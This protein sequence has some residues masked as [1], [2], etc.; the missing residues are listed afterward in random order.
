MSADAA[1]QP[2]TMRIDLLQCPEHGAGL[3]QAPGSLRCEMGHEIAV[4]RG[5][6]I[7]TRNARREETPSNMAALA[8]ESA[9]GA[10][11]AFVDDWIVNTHG[12]LYWHLRGHLPR[13]PIPEWPGR[14]A[15]KRGEVLIDI[16]CSWGRWTI[17]GARAGYEAWGIDVHLDALWAAGRVA[18]AAKVAADF[19]CSEAA[20]LPF[21]SGSVDFVFSYSVLQHLD[22]PTAGAVLREI[23]RIL[24]P[25]GTCLVQL[26][27]AYGAM[28][29]V[30]QARR[31]FRDGRPGTFEMRYWKRAEIR[32]AFENAGAGSI[33]FRPEGFLL[34]NTQRGDIDLLSG[35]GAAAVR[36]SCL[37]RSVAERLPVLGRAADSLWIEATKQ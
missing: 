14:I 7:F 2:K 9:T 37:L 32:A 4:E 10:V 29:A 25:G 35:A 31:G 17:A 19:V 24:R 22:R 27:N 13:Y 11:D 6:P 1:L 28:S 23:V 21:K 5:V 8:A 15:G 26:P 34:Q 12:N 33:S 20:Q 30:R 16:G 3:Q 18:R 36:L